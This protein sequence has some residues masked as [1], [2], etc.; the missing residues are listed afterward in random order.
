MISGVAL[1]YCTV[2]TVRRFLKDDSE[3]GLVYLVGSTLFFVLV[4]IFAIKL[5]GG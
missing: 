2:Q 4:F 5:V 1:W 3:W